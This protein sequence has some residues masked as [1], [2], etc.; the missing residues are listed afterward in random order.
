M[1]KALRSDKKTVDV[2]FE[3]QKEQCTFKPIIK[4]LSKDDLNSSKYNPDYNAPEAVLLTNK[5]VQ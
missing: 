5:H 2:E 1:R 4:P 3:Q